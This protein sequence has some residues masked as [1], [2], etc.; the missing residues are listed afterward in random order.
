MKKLIAIL[1]TIF[2]FFCFAGCDKTVEDERPLTLTVSIKNGMATVS[3]GENVAE[4]KIDTS[5]NP[6]ISVTENTFDLAKAIIDNR[7]IAFG[8]WKINVGGYSSSGELVAETEKSVDFNIVELNQQNIY[9]VLKGEYTT[10][11]Y[12]LFSEDIYLYGRTNRSTGGMSD[13][14]TVN[15]QADDR[16]DNNNAL[17]FFNKPLTATVDGN[18]YT[19]N[20][21]VDEHINWASL[22]FVY[23][24][25]FSEITSNGIVKNLQ[26][27]S[28][29]VYEVKSRHYSSASFVYKLYGKLENVFIS[30]ISR[31]MIRPDEKKHDTDNYLDK[32]DNCLAII[33]QAYDGA[34]IR[35]C[36]LYSAIYNV[37][38]EA[39]SGGGV[40]ARS[41][42][43][44]TYNNLAFVSKTGEARFFNPSMDKKFYQAP[45]GQDHALNA[46]NILFYPSINDLILGSG[47]KVDGNLSWTPTYVDFSGD[48]LSSF[49]YAWKIEDGDI[50]L[51]DKQ[52][53]IFE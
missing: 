23:G 48:S 53:I 15:F 3:G 52:I 21:A 49:G 10:S 9:N 11:D 19:L 28:D 30:Q 7:A 45:D 42:V 1:L 25:V 43:G 46:E 8:E 14:H 51:L 2:T 29:C 6:L 47:K 31:P 36:V 5:G 32:T 41:E 33:S 18:G 26:V 39:I 22:P 50:F 44:V 40:V 27:F 38:G 24:G 12:F 35:N 20:V 16:S 34:E 37:K 13:Y 17:F 4:Y